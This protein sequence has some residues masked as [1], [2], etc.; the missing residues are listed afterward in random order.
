MSTINDIEP[1]TIAKWF[2][3][4]NLDNPSNTGKGNMKIKKLLFFSQL[5]YM[6]MVWY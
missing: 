6:K 5:I 4:Q 2:I 1:R 3:A